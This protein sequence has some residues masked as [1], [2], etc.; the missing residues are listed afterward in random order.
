MV[1]GGELAPMANTCICLPFPAY[2]TPL[3]DTLLHHSWHMFILWWWRVD[4]KGKETLEIYALSPQEQL[5]SITAMKA[6]DNGGIPTAMLSVVGGW[7]LAQVGVRCCPSFEGYLLKGNATSL[8]LVPC[9]GPW[10]CF[11]E[12][13]R[14]WVPAQK[15][16][17]GCQKT[18]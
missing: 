11:W 14:W 4:I 16:R 1:F 7:Q 13:T 17:G 6:G 3:L 8:G 12:V 2:P 5:L 18:H 10:S 9:F 15:I